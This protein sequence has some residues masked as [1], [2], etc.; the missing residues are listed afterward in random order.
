MANRVLAGN[1][2]DGGYGLYVSKANSNVLTCDKKDLLFDSTQKTGGTGQIYAGGFKSSLSSA[3]NFVTATG[4]TKPSLGYI[5]LVIHSEDF[6]GSWNA[7]IDDSSTGVVQD[8]FQSRID[9]LGT[10]LTTIEPHEMA[11]GNNPTAGRRTSAE[12]N[13]F[14]GS[15]GGHSCTN[16]NFVVLKIPCAYGYMTSTYFT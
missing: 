12:A 10:T 7:F 5:P 8:E 16:L 15:G 11:D 3:H 4:N 14:G 13:I 6:S 2:S 1:R 9:L